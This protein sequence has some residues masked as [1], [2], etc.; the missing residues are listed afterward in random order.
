[1]WVADHGEAGQERLR[2]AIALVSRVGGVGGAVA[3]QL[4]A[5]GVGRLVLAHAGNTKP[6]DL[7]RQL[8]MTHDN[9][10]RSRVACAARRLRELN[11]RLDVV[12]VAENASD[13]NAERLLSEADLVVDCAPLFAERFA[14]NRAAVRQRKPMVE[15]AAYEMEGYVTTFVPGD[16]PCLACLYPEDPA[17]WRRE[18]PIFGAVANTIGCLGAVEAIKL[19]SGFGEPL[20]SRLFTIDLRA[21]RTRTLKLRRDPTCAV[22]GT[23]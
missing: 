6:G 19:L 21:M 10:G 18:F 15:C 12:A 4:A 5:A 17:H 23:V 1:M 14:L 13:A 8:L 9:L 11:P 3:Y 22:C 20:G 2:A 16:T 7:N